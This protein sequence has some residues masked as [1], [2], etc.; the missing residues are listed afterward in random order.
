[1]LPTIEACNLSK[2]GL[3][4]VVQGFALSIAVDG[5]LNMGRL[6]L[7]TVKNNCTSLINV[8]LLVSERN[9][10]IG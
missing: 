4:Y 1:M 3:N 7:A 9:T 5:T 10:T 8:G 6:D 2:L